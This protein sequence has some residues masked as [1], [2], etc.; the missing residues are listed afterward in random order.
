MN[1]R[2]ALYASAVLVFYMLGLSAWAWPQIPADARIAVHWN[3]SNAPNGYT[4]KAIGLFLVS[5]I[6]L[7]VGLILAGYPQLE[8][9]RFN[10]WGSAK[11]YNV[12]WAA[13]IVLLAVVQTS[14]VLSAVGRNVNQSLVAVTVI[15]AMLVTVGNYLGKVRSNFVFGIRTPWTLSSELAWDRT[16]RL[17]GRLFVVLGIVLLVTAWI[18]NGA[19]SFALMAVGIGL[20]LV[21]T[22]GYSYVV[23][24][25]DPSKQA[26]GRQS[27]V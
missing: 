22:A 15:G 1:R 14:L 21:L 11:A 16:H 12:V 4:G 13:S 7:V 10:L 18:G 25:A 19:L 6:A 26:V 5:A 3:A 24:R 9:R 17:G 23:W 20:I 2:P 27:Y 8:P